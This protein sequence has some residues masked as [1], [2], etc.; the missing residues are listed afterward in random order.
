M[1]GELFAELRR[2]LAAEELVALATVVA[3][4]GLGRQRLLGPGRE[5]LGGLGTPELDRFAVERAEEQLGSFTSRRHDLAAEAAGTAAAVSL[6]LEVHP[7]RPKLVVVGAVHTAIPLVALAKVLGFRTCVVDPRTAFATRERFPHADELITDW[8]QE[9]LPRLGLNESSYVTALSH[10]LKIDVPALAVAL[11][12]RAR[13]VGALGSR[14][15]QA[16]RAAALAEA[17]LSAEEIARVRTP[18]GLDLGGQ[19]PEEIAVSI[20][21]EIVAASHGLGA[22]GGGR[23]E[24]GEVA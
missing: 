16:K 7:P 6:F 15:T 3:G 12:S 19:R 11:R 24:A 1:R 22:P 4:P 23:Q 20:I 5:P 21:A 18:I 13:Y 9:A 10:D 17:G 14:K 2:R 8:P